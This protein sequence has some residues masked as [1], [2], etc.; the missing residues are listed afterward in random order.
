[1]SGFGVNFVSPGDTGGGGGGGTPEL[2]GAN[3]WEKPPTPNALDDEFEDDPIDSAW[4]YTGFGAPL[5]FGTAPDP[6]ANLGSSGHRAKAAHNRAGIGAGSWLVMQLDGGSGNGGVQKPIG[7]P[8]TNQ[9]C[10]ARLGFCWRNG[11]GIS[12]NDHKIALCLFETGQMSTSIPLRGVNMALCDTDR[13]GADVQAAYWGR[14]GGGFMDRTFGH[15]LNDAGSSNEGWSSWAGYVGIQKLGD[16]Y[17]GWLANSETGWLYMG[18]IENDTGADWDSVAVW[19]ANVGGTTPGNMLV[20]CDFV[21][22]VD[23]AVFLP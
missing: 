22:F 14:N 20:F 9:F 13:S 8:P 16:F 19:G 11:V 1:M 3:L 23:S 17:H 10:W 7:T 6:Y 12:T 5:G 18:E 15:V 4:V 2:V 21:R